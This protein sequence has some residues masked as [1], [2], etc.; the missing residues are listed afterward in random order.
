M[1][2]CGILLND[3]CGARSEDDSTEDSG[4]ADKIEEGD[5]CVVLS[6]SRAAI[7][8]RTLKWAGLKQVSFPQESFIFGSDVKKR[9]ILVK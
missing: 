9:T 4:S 1:S 2:E 3:F 8:Q 7:L 6:L 5:Y